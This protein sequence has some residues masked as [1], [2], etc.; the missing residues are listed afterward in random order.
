MKICECVRTNLENIKSKWPPRKQGDGEGRRRAWV[1]VGLG[2]IAL[3]IWAPSRVE[4]SGQAPNS[5]R[6][7]LP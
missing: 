5:L 7:I 4:R 1:G 2:D 3:K 6:A